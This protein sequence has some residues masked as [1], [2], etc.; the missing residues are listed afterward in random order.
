MTGGP[1]YAAGL[2]FSCARC[3]A[4]CTGEPGYVWVDDL[5]AEALARALGLGRAEFL[6]RHTRRALG[7]TSLREAAD[8]R[9]ALF[10]PG[11]GCAAY[12]QRPRQCRTWPFW[13]RLLA[14][15]E[16]WERAAADCPGM[17]AGELHD[18]AAIERI[19]GVTA[20]A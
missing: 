5:E 17:G 4:C 6:R 11:E 15:R 12:A 16:A 18:L 1:W 10:V 7:R 14:S 2:R 9:C 3:G 13:P 19:A 20:P 8:G